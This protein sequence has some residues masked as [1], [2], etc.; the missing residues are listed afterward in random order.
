M[1][2]WPMIARGRLWKETILVH[3]V[4]LGAPSPNVTNWLAVITW[5]GLIFL[6]STE[7][8]SD[9]NTE[10][11]IG[12]SLSKFFP[13][14]SRHAIDFLHWVVR[15]LGHFGEFFI[16]A[17]LLM[18]ALQRRPDEHRIGLAIALTTLYAVGDELHQSLVPSRSSSALD[19]LTDAVGGICGTLWFCWRNRRKQART[20]M[21]S[22]AETPYP[23]K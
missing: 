4:K 9:S 1:A 23:A 10:A 17:I 19:V 18:R 8:F 14:I 12:E 6:F 13:S 2:V 3:E 5:A 11:V 15:K 22:G 16:L 7:I 20:R 21:R